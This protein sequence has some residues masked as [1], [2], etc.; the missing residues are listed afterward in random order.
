MPE[1]RYSS[2]AV[3]LAAITA[4]LHLAIAP[5][6]DLSVDEAHYALYAHFLDWSYYDHPPMVGWLLWLLSPLGL[7]EFTLRLPSAL[8]YLACC[9][10]LYVLSARVL[11]GGTDKQGFITVLLFSLMPMVQLLGFGMVPEVPLLLIALLLV[12]AVLRLDHQPSLRNWL[13]LGLLLGL[14]GL[15]KYTAVLLVGGIGL[16]WLLNRQLLARLTSPGLWL[17]AAVALITITPVIGWNANHD[18]ASFRYQIDHAAGGEWEFKEVL[19]AFA[20][21]LVVYTPL[22]LTAVLILSRDVRT[23]GPRQLL[24]CMALPILVFVLAGSGNGKSLPHWALLAWCLALPS[25][26][27]WACHNWRSRGPRRFISFSTGMC[28]LLSVF[29]LVLL[30]FKPLGLIPSLAPTLTDL[31]GWKEAAQRASTLRKK[32]FKEDG[33]ILLNNWSRASRIAWYAQP[34]TVQVL[35][36][37]PGQFAFWYGSPD[38]DTVGILIRDNLDDDED[39]NAPY[40]KLGLSCDFLES[41]NAEIGGTV[42]NRFYFYRCRP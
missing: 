24:A 28:T 36:T 18:W 34:D 6:V 5:V 40:S 22:I 11:E 3:W 13:V 8:I 41:Q 16:Y 21:Q 10:L 25:L 26:A 29:V 37:R 23:H 2:Y 32:H 27:H 33:V 15:T 30:A 20:V 39:P 12:F 17:G 9:Y 4:L 14:A 35:S 7:N 19:R 42:V 38:A 1:T 31:V